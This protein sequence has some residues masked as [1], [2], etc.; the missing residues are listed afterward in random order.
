M[1]K[2]IQKIV[3]FIT[4]LAFGLILKAD[5]NP[6]IKNMSTISKTHLVQDRY[7]FIQFPKGIE[8]GKLTLGFA[9]QLNTPSVQ[10]SEV[11]IEGF[12][13]QKNNIPITKENNGLG[14][15]FPEAFGAGATAS[16]FY[17]FSL[18][19]GQELESIKVSWK[20]GDII[21]KVSE[22]M[23]VKDM[24]GQNHPKLDK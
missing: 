15:T 13:Q 20:G 1:Q 6:T 23:L 18:E 9:K 19:K 3:P 11:K 17:V 10:Y 24:P 21:F 5:D 8:A 4:L 14:E 12:D 7:V 22:L 16:G 2:F